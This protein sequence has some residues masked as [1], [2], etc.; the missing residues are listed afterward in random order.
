[1]HGSIIADLG[2]DILQQ[3]GF[4]TMSYLNLGS[5]VRYSSSFVKLVNG[6]LNVNFKMILI[7]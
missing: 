1:M 2:S 7:F 6:N 3:N 4:I 5:I